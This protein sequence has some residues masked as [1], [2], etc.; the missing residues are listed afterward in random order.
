MRTH[1]GIVRDHSA[2]MSSLTRGAKDDYNVLIRGL[3]E[4]AAEENQE[5]FLSTIKCGVGHRASVETELRSEDIRY[6]NEINSYSATGSATPLW[7]S[8][9]AAIDAVQTF[10]TDSDDA[11]LIM[12]IT[13]G[14]ENASR[15]KSHELAA[16]ISRLQATDKW[17]FVFRVPKGNY[18]RQLV[19]TL[20]V[21]EGNVIEWELNEQALAYSTE[22]TVAA[23]KSYMKSRAA[24]KTSTTAFYVDAAQLS[25]KDVKVALTEVTDNVNVIVVPQDANGAEIRPFCEK[26]GIVYKTGQAYY[27]LTKPE[28]VQ[29]NK[30]IAVR[31][32]KSGAIY[33][34]LAA[35][36]LLGLPLYQTVKVKPSTGD[37]AQ[38]DIFIQS[39]S[40]NRKLVAGTALLYFR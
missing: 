37:S 13:D 18:R 29:D 24:G 8:V 14:H 30:M 25:P 16:I 15:T 1:V 7:D 22:V 12:V 32:K 21:P 9:A 23:T 33:H 20:N 2:S 11:Y 3:K 35:R 26:Q 36:Q 28:T 38:F 4:S 27:Q 40:V 19:R 31:E 34:G 5:I 39:N 10:A 17:T 6:V